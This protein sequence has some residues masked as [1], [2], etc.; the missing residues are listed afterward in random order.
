MSE[1]KFTKQHLEAYEAKQFKIL[2]DKLMSGKALNKAENEFYVAYMQKK[3]DIKDVD[4]LLVVGTNA[5]SYAKNQSDL[6]KA[7]GVNRKT[8]QRWKKDPTFPKE[9]PDG[10]YNIREV[11]E[12]KDL[13]GA[14]AGDITSKES[15]QIRSMMLQNEKLEIQV[16]IL[17]GEYTP[18]VDIDQQVSE[19][20]Q[21]AKRELL[22]LPSSLAPQV[23][24]QSIAEAEK[25]IKQGVV[26][27]L[28]SLHEN[29]W[30]THSNSVTQNSVTEKKEREDG[31]A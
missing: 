24:G 14:R 1:K 16:G 28:K 25:I 26:D 17:R 18:N 5:T 29:S 20:V 30:T 21:Q 11:V 15:E 19:M 2:T 31:E 4:D 13:H 9:K 3:G 23:V 27:A 8:I 22:S 7:I 12:W 10:R 6:A